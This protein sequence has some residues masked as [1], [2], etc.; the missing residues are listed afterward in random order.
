[1]RVL[2]VGDVFGKPGRKAFRSRLRALSLEAEFDLVIINGENA[3]GGFGITRKVADEIFSDGAGVI[4]SG[5]HIWDKKE[6]LGL[7]E[8]EPRVIRPANYPPGVPGSGSTVVTTRSGARIGVLNLAGR[9]F[10]NT[11]DCPFRAASH[12]IGALREKCDSIIVDFHAEATSEKIAMGWHLDGKVAAVL[13]THTHVQTADERILPG[14]TAYI[15]DVGM[16]GPIN[17]VIG[18]RTDQILE[19]FLLQMPNR[20]EVAEGPVVFSA[21]VVVIDEST[22]LASSITRLYEIM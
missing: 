20:Y 14:A 7:L 21:V 19:R 2:F 13:G 1:M 16:T 10:M 15:S 17:S 22:G 4:T 12:E 6:A 11:L 8:E 5:N 3:A 18:V 9:V